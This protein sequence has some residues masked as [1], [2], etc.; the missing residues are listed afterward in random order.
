MCLSHIRLIMH[1]VCAKYVLRHGMHLNHV[2]I[3]NMRLVYIGY[4]IMQGMCLSRIKIANECLV[5]IRYA[6]LQ[7][8]CLS[9]VRL[10]KMRLVYIGYA[11]MHFIFV[12][13]VLIA[14][15]ER[16]TKEYTTKGEREE[17]HIF[18]LIMN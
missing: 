13:P 16:E 15:K 4:T 12:T 18:I 17:V 5:C 10:T 14:V 8:M 11:I 1:L 6:I 7:E 2:R 3:A 9:R